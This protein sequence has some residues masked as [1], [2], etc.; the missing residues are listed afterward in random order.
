MDLCNQDREPFT[1]LG[2]HI[3][4]AIGDTSRAALA[5]DASSRGPA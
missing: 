3:N 2:A 5:A 4:R 1:P